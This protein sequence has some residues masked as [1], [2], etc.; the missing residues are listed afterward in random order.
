MPRFDRA[1]DQL[2]SVMP[3]AATAGAIWIANSGGG[4]AMFVQF[5]PWTIGGIAEALSP[6]FF[7]QEIAKYSRTSILLRLGRV[8]HLLFTGFHL[9]I[10]RSIEGVVYSCI[11]TKFSCSRVAVRVDVFQIDGSCVSARDMYPATSVVSC[12]RSTCWR[13]VLWRRDRSLKV[14]LL[15]ARVAFLLPSRFIGSHS[16]PCCLPTLIALL[17]PHFVTPTT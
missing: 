13:Y 14:S 16:R 17:L 5:L 3:A 15:A 9:V 6:D 12:Q 1:T 4:P 7:E 2:H 11:Y 8:C 10:D